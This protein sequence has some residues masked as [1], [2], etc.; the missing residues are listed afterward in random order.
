MNMQLDSISEK[1]EEYDHSRV[2]T[3]QTRKASEGQY[4]ASLVGS[5]VSRRSFKKINA[6]SKQSQHNF[7]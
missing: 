4:S 1:Q 6:S 3:I 7:N 2:Q 5:R